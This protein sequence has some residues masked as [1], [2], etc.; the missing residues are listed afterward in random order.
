MKVLQVAPYFHPHIGGVESHVLDLSR[1][2]VRLGFRIE[3]VTSMYERMKDRESVRGLDVVRLKPAAIWWKTPVTFKLKSYVS[4]SDADIVHAHSPPPLDSYF[5]ARACRASK[6]PFVITY[7]CD[8]EIPGV[9]GPFV[10]WIYERTF[11]SYTVSSSDK[12]IVTTGT[13]A[14][15]SRSVWNYVPVVI[16]NAVDSNMFNP[17]VGGT[18]IRKRHNIASDEK[19]V[20]FVGRLVSHKGIEHLLD[21]ARLVPDVKFIIVGGGEF[22][23]D[24]RMR[25]SHESEGNVIFAGR[26]PYSDLPKYYA[27]CDVSVL[28]SVSRLEAFGIAALEGMSSGKPVVVSDIPGVREVITDGEEGLLCEPLN[29][30]DLARK[31]TF[32]MESD[33]RRRGMGARGREK[34][35]KY[36]NI[37]RIAKSVA[38]VYESLA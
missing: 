31:I 11:G 17:S 36:F 28:P 35:E 4:S 32:L 33:A 6:K 29:P 10:V 27:A 22:A 14:A 1:E 24:L 37:E 3:V 5:V 16:P 38:E 23:D 15:T 34:I 8:L 20:L 9:L 2:L 19:V 18:G 25:H 13:Y 30:E 26:V 7:H 12:I 21:A